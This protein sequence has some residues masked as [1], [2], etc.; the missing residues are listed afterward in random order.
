MNLKILFYISAVLQLSTWAFMF[1]LDYESN[2]VSFYI[3]EVLTVVNIAYLIFFYRKVHRPIQALTDGLDL[4]KGQD[5]NSS[6]NKIGQP[7]VD[8][9]ADTFNKMITLLKE[10]RLRFEEQSHFLNLLI[11][12]APIGVII[13][14]FDERGYITNDVAKRML[15]SSGDSMTGTPVSRLP[16]SLGQCL[17]SLS[18]A[19]S[20]IL[21]TGGRSTFKCSCYNLVDKGIAHKFFLIEDVGD[22][23]ADAERVAY[24]KIIRIIAHE[25]N[26]TVA[27]IASAI[28]VI[29]DIMDQ[30]D[31]VS[32]LLQSCSERAL[33]MSAFVQRLADVVKIPEPVLQQ[34][35]IN[36]LIL[37]NRPFLESLC[38][39]AGCRLDFDLSEDAPPCM[40]DTPLIE[41]SLVNIVKNAVESISLTERQGVVTITT[42]RSASGSLSL[43][44]TDNGEG[45]S[46]EKNIKIF[47]PFYTD[48][49]SGQGV[50]LTFVREVLR[51]HGCSYSLRTDP[52]ELTRFTIVFPS[53]R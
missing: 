6:L 12:R 31:E 5:W 29:T 9:I 19:E 8:K 15:A 38:L 51:R 53:K 49:P 43:T 46:P 24:E 22:A 40:A 50:G 35:Q 3:L 39:P 25:V 16:G 20:R 17:A 42:C 30:G 27:P 36:D 4:R 45:I 11:A 28:G 44:V 47:T 34:C 33:G 41:Q 26:N 18:N 14:D 48:K 23:M 21:R 2:R 1:S 7:E 10:Q 13:L 52:D 32:Q 37:R